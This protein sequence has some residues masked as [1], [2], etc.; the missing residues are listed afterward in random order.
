MEN[1]LTDVE[2]TEKI[3]GEKGST[4]VKLF[5]GMNYRIEK[6]ANEFL[7]QHKDRIKVR[8]IKFSE[9]P[10]PTGERVNGRISRYGSLM[11]IFDVL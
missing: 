7:S 2:S 4:Q 6:D 8:D 3:I 11:I 10:D 5:L 9:H 1:Q